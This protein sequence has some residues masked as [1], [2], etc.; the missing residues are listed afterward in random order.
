MKTVQGYEFQLGVNHLG[1]F[2]LLGML[3]PAMQAANK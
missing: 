2:A 3:L 1:H